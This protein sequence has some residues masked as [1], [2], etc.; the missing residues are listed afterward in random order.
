MRANSVSRCLECG[1]LR[2]SLLS[3]ARGGCAS[4]TGQKLQEKLTNNQWAWAFTE[5]WS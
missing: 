4:R 2:F 3:F 5:L 1:Q